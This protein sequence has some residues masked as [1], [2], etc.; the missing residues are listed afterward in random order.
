[1]KIENSDGTIS[2]SNVEGART[3]KSGISQKA[4]KHITQILTR[5]YNDPESA[6]FREYV[7]N[8]L[9]A[10]KAAGTTEPIDIYLPNEA[11]PVF[12]VIDSGVGMSPMDMELIYSQYGE[13]TKTE[14]DDEIGG[15]GLGCKS[16]LAIATQFTIVSVKDGISTHAIYANGEDG[17]PELDI[18]SE[19][20]TDKSN[21]TTITIPIKN[22]HSF[23]QKAE[24]YF[25]FL[26]KDSFLVAGAV[27]DVH[28]TDALSNARISENTLEDGSIVRTYRDLYNSE[29]RSGVYVVMGGIYYNIPTNDIRANVPEIKDLPKEL[30][31]TV[32]DAITIIEC[33]IGS[34]RLSPNREGI[35]FTQKTQKFFSSIFVDSISE[36]KKSL[37]ESITEAEHLSEAMDRY[38]NYDS[39]LRKIVP[40][41]WN[42]ISLNTRE[43][44]FFPDHVDCARYVSWEDKSLVDL[45][46]SVLVSDM[47]KSSLV[48][49]KGD[50]TERSFRS[51]ASAFLKG[52]SS[53]ELIYYIKDDLKI[54][55]SR[56][57]ITRT[58][59]VVDPKT[60]D[61][62]TIPDP[63]YL[64]KD[65][66]DLAFPDGIRV[67]E[68]EEYK[69]IANEWRKN[70]KTKVTKAARTVLD[71]YYSVVS[72]D[73]GTLDSIQTKDIDISTFE[74]VYYVSPGQEVRDATSRLFLNHNGKLSEPVQEALVDLY[75]TDSIIIRLGASNTVERLNKAMR[76]IGVEN[77]P[78]PVDPDKIFN[79]LAKRI[80][81]KMSDILGYY[82]LT[83][84][85]ALFE[86]SRSEVLDTV[87][88]PKIRKLLRRESYIKVL[89]E[90]E[91]VDIVPRKFFKEGSKNF[92]TAKTLK[93]LTRYRWDSVLF[94]EGHVENTLKEVYS[95]YPL[96]SSVNPRSAESLEHLAL[97][98]NTV[99]RSNKSPAFTTKV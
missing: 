25:Q 76:M 95:K 32:F 57:K 45:R 87:R 99:H 48:F 93:D 97:Y 63:E 8:A 47:E 43:A 90:F 94:K 1:M 67:L 6:V 55:T 52:D 13:S 35:Q 24:K 71:T 65:Q 59:E 7:A 30:I 51:Y 85:K 12:T 22:H 78:I 27:H 64:T 79:K 66:L 88:D 19:T 41:E 3:I 34:V 16:A 10:H 5:L 92:T 39:D 4:M 96:V 40:S 44:V 91:I 60:K 72:P 46:S 38:A 73:K 62:R 83:E 42:G 9:D 53:A 89:D 28:Y 80:S 11:A 86:L 84:N 29:I 18:I 98:L 54:N 69:N 49:V 81:C 77:E 14:S 75:G 61:V 74:Q 82:V 58:K 26:A 70:N 50:K 17:Q 36:F 20:K 23:N 56:T 2:H 68:F 37:I 33:P 15:F 21:G 31:S